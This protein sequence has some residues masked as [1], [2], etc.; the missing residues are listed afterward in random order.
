MTAIGIDDD[1]QIVEAFQAAT[2]LWWIFLVIGTA[3]LLFAI[4][5]FRFDWRS[6]SAI[7]IVFGVIM[8]AAALDEVL[9]AFAGGQSG[10]MVALRL[11]VAAALVVIGVIAFIHPGNT[12][13]AL[14]AVMSFYFIIK[15][16]FTIVVAIATRKDAELWWLL[17]VVGFAELLLGFWAAG[18][19]GHRQILLIVWVGAVAFARGISAI[20]FGFRVRDLREAAA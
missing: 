7:S 4:M 12:F 16:A 13:A 20:V 17:L 18:D 10:W 15:G 14:A 11:V 5:V 9:A 8:L 1:R 19:F 2:R 6:V 3:W